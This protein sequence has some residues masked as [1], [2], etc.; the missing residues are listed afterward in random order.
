VLWDRWKLASARA[1]RLELETL[2]AAGAQG[3]ELMLDLKGHDPRLP[4]R[5]LGALAQAGPG[6]RVTVCSQDWALLEPLRGVEDLRIV[7]SVGSRRALGTLLARFA[8]DRLDG[9]SIHQRLLDP[10]IAAELRTRADL[11][12]SWPVES[13]AEGHRLVGLGVRGLISQAFELLSAVFAPPV[14]PRWAV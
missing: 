11:L 3:P 4:A 9:V 6:R 13:I 12:L 1:P 8:G 14:A 2:L 10:T 5:L 7:H